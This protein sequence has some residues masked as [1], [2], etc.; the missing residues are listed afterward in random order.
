MN[1]ADKE[2]EGPSWAIVE[3]MGHVKYGGLIS[4]D[5]QFGTAMLR[6]DVPQADGTFVTQLINPTSIYRLTMASEALARA[7][8]RGGETKPMAEWEV[9]H[10]MPASEDPHEPFNDFDEEP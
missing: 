8:A 2:T 5:N 7:A 4:K 6:L 1:E 10:L 9:K 3:L